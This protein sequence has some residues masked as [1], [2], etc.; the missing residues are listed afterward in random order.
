MG[1]RYPKNKDMLRDMAANG[2]YFSDMPENIYYPT[3]N[4]E[5]LLTDWSNEIADAIS[6][7]RKV[8]ISISHSPGKETGIEHRI[9]NLIAR[10]VGEVFERVPVNELLI[11]GGSTASEILKSLEITR[12]APFQELAAGVIRMKVV[13]RPDLFLTTK[14]GSYVWPEKVWMK[15]EI[16]RF[17]TAV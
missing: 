9:K 5:K 14:P 8:I 13:S 7:F 16:E 4:N 17:N 1:S 15:D 11:E 10:V 3:N 12:L 2:L 6:K